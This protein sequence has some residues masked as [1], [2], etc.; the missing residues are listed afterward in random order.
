FADCAA[1]GWTVNGDWQCGVPTSGPNGSPTQTNVLAT[2]L[3]GNYGANVGWGTQTATTPPFSLA[4]ASAPVAE[5]LVWY[6]TETSWD[7]WNLKIST[8]GTNFTTVPSVTPAYTHTI[9]SQSA[10]S[11]SRTSWSVIQ[12]DL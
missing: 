10:W 9:S 1:H 3:A 8:D 2:N 4:G 11:G 6:H 12:A 5:I 7:G